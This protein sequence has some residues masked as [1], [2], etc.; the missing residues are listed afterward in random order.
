MQNILLTIVN[1]QRE[2]YADHKALEAA[3]KELGHGVD[4][5]MSTEKDEVKRRKLSFT[6]YV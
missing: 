6:S 1:K 5:L 2:Q 3:I 4:V